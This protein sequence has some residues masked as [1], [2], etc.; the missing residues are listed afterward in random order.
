M[1][2]SFTER[3]FRCKNNLLLTFI[4]L[5]NTANV[6]IVDLTNHFSSNITKHSEVP[7]SPIRVLWVLSLIFSYCKLNLLGFG[8]FL[9]QH[10]HIH[11]DLSLCVQV[12]PCAQ[13][14]ALY[15]LHENGCITLRVCRSTTTAEEATGMKPLDSVRTHRAHAIGTVLTNHSNSCA[16]VPHLFNW[17]ALQ[18]EPVAFLYAPVG[19]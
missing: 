13:R 19:I 14:D 9:R 16:I 10:T 6:L 11:P 12:I 17:T 5:R 15:C 3:A 18:S 4:L 8:L 1:L 7:G 2:V